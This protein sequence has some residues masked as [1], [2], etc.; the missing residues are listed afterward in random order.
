MKKKRNMLIRLIRSYLALLIKNDRFIHRPENIDHYIAE[1][2]QFYKI[3]FIVLISLFV[4]CTPAKKTTK[5]EVKSDLLQT[6]EVKKTSDE[7]QSLTTYVNAEKN[8]E[9]SIKKNTSAE[10]TEN[11]ETTVHTITYDTK[12]KVDSIT[13]RPAVAT[14]TIQKTVKGKNVK[15][16]ESIETLYSQAEVQNLFSV[17]FKLSKN[18][19]D[20]VNKVISSLKS[21]VIEKTKQANGWWKWLLFGISLPVILLVVWKFTSASKLSFLLNKIKLIFAK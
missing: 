8:A 1:I 20:S 12:T 16:L 4:S 11:E 10:T 18:A 14:E 19:S 3:G 5:S 7:N 9:E 13:R 6:T 21:E 2:Q 17:Y 15:A